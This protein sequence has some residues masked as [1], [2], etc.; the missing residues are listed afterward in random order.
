MVIKS[1]L[2]EKMQIGEKAKQIAENIIIKIK[3]LST[4]PK[5][6]QIIESDNKRLNDVRSMLYRKYK[7]LY[8]VRDDTQTVCILRII[9]CG[10]DINKIT[11]D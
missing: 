6:Y 2:L 5:R 4:F 7:I 3:T 1:Y 9:Y 8:V 11:T 10:S